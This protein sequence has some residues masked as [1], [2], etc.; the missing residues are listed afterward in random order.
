MNKNIGIVL[1]G[2]ALILTF[3]V[4]LDISYRHGVQDCVKAVNDANWCKNELAK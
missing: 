1:I 4:C 3:M 2:L